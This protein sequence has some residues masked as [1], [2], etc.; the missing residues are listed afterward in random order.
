M[1]HAAVLV[2]AALLLLAL[3][4]A[5]DERNQMAGGEPQLSAESGDAAVSRRAAR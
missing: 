1:K 4:I 5:H 2:Y 3:A